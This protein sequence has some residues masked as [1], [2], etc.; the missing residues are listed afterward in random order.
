MFSVVVCAY[1]E[2][3]NIGDLLRRMPKTI[4]K[5]RIIVV[6]DGSSDNTAEIAKS[7]RVQVIRHEANM[8]K[9]AAIRTG[10]DAAKTDAVVLMDGDNQHDPRE[11][12][13]LLDAL[14]G[15]DMV[16][17]SRFLSRNKMPA[18]R[19]IANMLLSLIS[20][21]AG[22]PV[23]DPVSGYRALRKSKFPGLK[24]SG[25]NLELELLYNARRDRLR[26]G[27]VPITVPFIEKRSSVLNYLPNA[28]SVYGSM[29][30][31]SLKRWL[32]G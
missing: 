1:N 24:E 18:Y 15:R 9:G 2:G 28:L 17:G 20:C 8:G 31:Y 32:L 23:T 3:K 16:I 19:T 29:L 12:K 6:D 22:V 5:K 4:P 13:S 21:I 27:E 11:V 25:F 7:F 10:L 14:Q 30:L 26:V